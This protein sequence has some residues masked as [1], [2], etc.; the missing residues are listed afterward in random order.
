MSPKVTAGMLLAAI[1]LTGLLF[2]LANH[3]PWLKILNEQTSPHQIH[4]YRHATAEIITMPL[5]E[6]LVGVVAAEMPASFPLEALKAQAVAARTYTLRRIQLNPPH[7]T[8]PGANICDDTRYSQAWIS[9]QQMKAR[10]GP[11]DYQQY[12]YKIKRAVTAT[13]AQVLT[14]NN[15]LINAVYHASCGGITENSGQVWQIDKPY[16]QSRPCPYCA[17]P[18]RV[19]SVSY[20]LEEISARLQTNLK[21][22][23][24]ATGSNSQIIKI[25]EKTCTGRPRVILIGNKIMP[26]TVFREKMSLRSTRF[27][28]QLADQQIIFTTT[29]HGHGVGMCQYGAKGLAKQQKNYWQILSHYYPGTQLK[30]QVKS[31]HWLCFQNTGY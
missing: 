28:Y 30:K 24:A 29:G 31:S 14:Y 9:K 2:Q 1:L 12:Y 8:H 15:E 18:R 17:D 22:L 11:V 3:L 27:T 10:W 6:Y 4:L 25:K 20:S 16:L 7:F 13:Q 26:A 19:Q 5:E 23:P 21:A